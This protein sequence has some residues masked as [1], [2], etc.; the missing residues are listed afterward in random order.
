[1]APFLKCITWA[2]S[3]SFLNPA[4]PEDNRPLV[5]FNHLCSKPIIFTVLDVQMLLHIY[6]LMHMK[7]EMGKVMTIRKT[8]MM[9]RSTESE[10]F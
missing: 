9:V 8:E 10:T 3:A 4:K 5:F 7:R 1:M 2:L 6:T